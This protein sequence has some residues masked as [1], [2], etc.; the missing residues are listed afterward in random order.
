MSPASTLGLNRTGCR[1]NGHSTA[2]RSAPSSQSG[3]RYGRTEAGGWALPCLGSTL[4]IF[5][6]SRQG[7]PSVG[8][9]GFGQKAPGFVLH[10]SVEGV[11]AWNERSSVAHGPRMQ[12]QQTIMS[13]VHPGPREEFVIGPVLDQESCPPQ[14]SQVRQI[15][16]RPESWYV[17]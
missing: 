5:V 16:Q 4:L 7:G 15:C 14:S 6:L 8:L 12:P 9:Q 3:R 1:T 2:S 17:Q 11:P 10:G 13:L